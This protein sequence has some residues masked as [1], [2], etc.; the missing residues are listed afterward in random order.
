MKKKYLRKIIIILLISFCYLS[1]AEPVRYSII[2]LQRK[3][4]D[5]SIKYRIFDNQKFVGEI[6]NKEFLSW[7]RNPGLME[8]L[9]ER[10]E[11]LKQI[12][13]NVKSGKIYE[14]EL[15][16]N[17]YSSN[18]LDLKEDLVEQPKRR[19]LLDFLIP[20]VIFFAVL[21][22]I[23]MRYFQQNRLKKLLNL[24]K[25]LSKKEKYEQAI[26]IFQ[27]LIKIKTNNLQA[28]QEL[29]IVFL[30]KQEFDKAYSC[31]KKIKDLL[32]NSKIEKMDISKIKESDIN[33]SLL[34]KLLKK[35]NH[36]IEKIN[37]IRIL[38]QGFSGSSVFLA[39]VIKK[40]ETTTNFAVLKID[41]N[42]LREIQKSNLQR[43]SSGFAALK[44][45]WN[46]EIGQH[47]PQEI[48]LFSELD[49]VTNKRSLLFSTFAEEKNTQNVMTLR[50][51][52][53]KKY[54]YYFTEISKIR[55]FYEKQF[56]SIPNNK[57]HFLKPL[58]HLR[59]IL[60]FKLDDLIKFNWEKAQIFKEKQFIN[61]DG[62]LFPNVICYLSKNNLWNNDGFSTFYFL[63]HGDFNL[64]NI[65]FKS[66]KNFVLIDFEKVRETVFHFDL[67][68]LICWFAQVFMLE[69][70][71]DKNW[72]SI[73]KF[74]PQ[75]VSYLRNPELK[76]ETL[77]ATENF[78]QILSEIYPFKKRFDENSR[79]S[80]L[81]SLITAS[82]L[83]SFYELRDFERSFFKDST[84][85]MNGLYFYALACQLLD[86]P[87]FI[88]KKSASTKDAFDL[89]EL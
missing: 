32:E 42:D 78:K 89:Q 40:E 10:E 61:I 21:F 4:P 52:L 39:E 88:K 54:S 60:E 71:S 34:L 50:E 80:F 37:I 45:N 23:L 73:F 47:L 87:D 15:F 14:I 86:D 75:I 65:I 74:I 6:S 49:L 33:L 51:G 20:F 84:N 53:Q 3:D 81:L 62:R 31:R 9:I 57:K 58:E 36:E 55:D 24:G 67:S 12:E 56:Y 8:I 5:I 28:W 35:E 7:K 18:I 82:L 27:K 69:T 85:K 44:Q 83:R 25:E 16:S 46:E 26:E 41:K 38:K 59:N 29:E 11:G 13:I 43:E 70:S 68:F 64:D 63:V 2:K 72:N 30:K 48:L 1:G 79:K 66:D 17:G 22:S 19:N 77:P 76:I